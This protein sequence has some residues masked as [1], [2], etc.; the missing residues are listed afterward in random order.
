MKRFRNTNQFYIALI[1]LIAII[2]V[3]S[4]AQAD[5]FY[6]V[7]FDQ[8]N[9][10]IA[11]GQSIQV[12]VLLEETITGMSQH[13]LDLAGG[14]FG[15]LNGNFGVSTSGTG[16]SQINSAAGNP[17]YDLGPTIT[18]GNPTTVSQGALLN[19]PVFGSPAGLGTRTVTLGTLS[20]TGSGNIGEQ[21][22][23]LPF[24]FNLGSDDFV[25]DDGFGGLNFVADTAIAFQ[26]LNVLLTTV[27]EPSSLY[28]SMA[29]AWGLIFHRRR[30]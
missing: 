9:L 6:V 11:T 7:R 4:I 17:L 25:I 3:G 12:S 22:T 18:L 26:G 19:P 2:Q 28:A 10:A 15:L 30:R 16:A 21:N 8:S 24:D 1:G 27:P 20:I 23:F 13:R 14:R 5:Y 29:M